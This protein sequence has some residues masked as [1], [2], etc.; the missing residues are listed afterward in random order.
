MCVCCFFLQCDFDGCEK[1]FRN[2]HH[3]KSHM[4][5]HTGQRPYACSDST[6]GRTFAKRHS[7]KSHLARHEPA[8]RSADGSTEN[9]DATIGRQV[10]DSVNPDE[11]RLTSVPSVNGV[12]GTAL[13][14]GSPEFPQN[15]TFSS[16]S[17][18]RT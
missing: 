14:F 2:S 7:W 18:D 16:L 4:L 15:S 11:I 9:P 10:L 8:G 17:F 5:S 13:G 6:C 1:T 12:Q 3:L